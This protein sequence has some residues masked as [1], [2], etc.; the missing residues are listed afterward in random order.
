M[1]IE[2]ATV[3]GHDMTAGMVCTYFGRGEQPTETGVVVRV[4][5]PG[6][7]Y[8]VI[9]GNDT[10]LDEF[11]AAV[12]FWAYGDDFMPRAAY[13]RVQDGKRVEFVSLAA[14]LPTSAD[15]S[16]EFSHCAHCSALI[17]RRADRPGR[18]WGHAASDGWWLPCGDGS[19]RKATPD[20]TRPAPLLNNSPHTQTASDADE[21]PLTVTAANLA[22]GDWANLGHDDAPLWV[23]ITD[24]PTLDLHDVQVI[25]LARGHRPMSTIL[26]PSCPVEIRRP[27][28]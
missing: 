3:K 5:K 16:V 2:N 13:R 15:E 21:Q 24:P 17:S 28:R 10:V 23:F 25:G 27:I 19:S 26:A 9:D 12:K 22:A 18:R 1:E 6:T 20:D 11:G 14:E 4:V 7:R 8:L